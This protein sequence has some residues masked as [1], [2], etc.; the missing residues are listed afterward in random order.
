MDKNS[1]IGAIK[2]RFFDREE[3][4]EYGK[5]QKQ[6]FKKT[7]QQIKQI[8][9]IKKLIICLNTRR[10]TIEIVMERILGISDIRT[11]EMS[12]NQLRSMMKLLEVD[13]TEEEHELF[14]SSFI[15]A[16][17]Q[18]IK[19]DEFVKTVYLVK[20]NKKKVS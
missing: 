6:L 2:Y 3:E 15:I 8:E 4:F 1:A 19:T 10:F 12:L 16:N 11:A 7:N 18:N 14:F 5:M 17:Q 20:R 9:I 13:C